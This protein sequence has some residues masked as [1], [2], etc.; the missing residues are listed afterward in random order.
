MFFYLIF[1]STIIKHNLDLKS[2][3]IQ[4]L[5]YGCV[6]YIIIH[7][8]LFI[9]G[10]NALLYN[11][12]TYFW[13]FFILDII[14]LCLLLQSKYN[15]N[16]EKILKNVLEMITKEKKII[17]QNKPII[18]TKETP[19]LKPALKNKNKNKNKSKG[20]KFN[21]PKKEYGY[22]SD[23]G[24]DSDSDSEAESEMNTDLD[25]DFK[26]FKQSLDFSD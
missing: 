23:S 2:K 18:P 8:T 25:I 24:S 20:V 16:F 15:I 4:T 7:A 11:F 12:K 13:L 21:L 1:N 17:A 5:L 9:G 19:I 6:A 3:I 10:E 14:V 26:Q 22:D